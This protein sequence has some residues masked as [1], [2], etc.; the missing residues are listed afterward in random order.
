MS[1]IKIRD[2]QRKSKT[3]TDDDRDIVR[4]R[5]Q[6]SHSE[7]NKAIAKQLNTNSQQP[8]TH[9]HK[10]KNKNLIRSIVSSSTADYSCSSFRATPEIFTQNEVNE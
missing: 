5:Q 8:I 3:T 7:T 9:K 1:N 6:T 4:Q 10:M 2:V